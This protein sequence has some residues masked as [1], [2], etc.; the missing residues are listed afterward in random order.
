MYIK[1]ALL[2][3]TLACAQHFTALPAAH[4]DSAELDT[5]V[6]RP[7]DFDQYSPRTAFDMVSR[8]PGFSIREDNSGDRGLGQA[9]GNVLINGRRISGKSVTTREALE[10]IPATNV[11]Q[12]SV[13]D[14]ATLD[15]PG[16]SGQVA[17][18]T[19]RVSG[20]SGTWDWSFRF[21]ENL[22]PAYDRFTV[23]VTGRQDA[24]T[25]T[26]GLTGDPIRGAA[27]GSE[28]VFDADGEIFEFRK[29]DV[30][31]LGHRPGVSGSLE[32]TPASGHVANLNA[33]YNL[34]EFDGREFSL[35]FPLDGRPDSKRFFRN[36]EDEWNAEIGGDYEFPLGPG[37]LKTIAL[38][39]FEHSP[40]LNS[41]RTTQADGTLSEHTIFKQTIDEGESILRGE[42]GWQPADGRDWQVSAEGAFN[43]LEADALLRRLDDAGDLVVVPLDNANARVEETRAEI[44]LTH[45]R[46]LSPD[47]SV[48]AS[49]GLEYSELSQSGDAAQTREFTR[50][51]GFVSLA[52]GATETLTVNARLAREV[53]QL[54]FGDFIS[55]VNLN[56]GNGSQGNPDIVPQ[57][58]WLGEIELE[59]DYGEA[60]AHTLTFAVESIEDIVDRIPFGPD[61]EGPGNLDKA[62]RYSVSANGTF[63]LDPVGFRGAQLDYDVEAGYSEIDDPLTGET[64]RISDDVVIGGLIEVRHDIPGTDLAWGFGT[65]RYDR[66][67]FVRLDQESLWEVRPAF[68]WAFVQHKDIFGMTGTFTYG[69]MLDTDEQFTRKVYDG[70][71]TNGL[72]FREDRTW[73]LGPI[74]TIGLEGSF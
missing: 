17:N 21:R 22:P 74:I 52:W 1:T 30:A 33:E 28:N 68:A 10:R 43:F 70:R 51:K 61:S 36:S 35:R 14:G 44:N 42:Y 32:W 69:N 65:E 9:E 15:V 11:E 13:V 26:L 12:I 40:Y 60:G 5:H 20:V 34:Y 45:G 27:K 19:A 6:F 25:W 8:I 41:V 38:W 55:S 3:G 73:N 72:L 67:P 56:A 57:Q 24:L 54:D 66:A 18:V 7:G 53:G 50:P 23:S 16:L 64:R 37:K 31:N 48:Q 2:A 4:A 63:K 59:K 71:R 49:L 47:I 58:S 39:R 29:L 62:T 46:R